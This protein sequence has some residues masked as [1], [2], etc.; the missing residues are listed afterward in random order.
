MLNQLQALLIFQN[1]NQHLKFQSRNLHRQKRV[2]NVQAGETTRVELV[3]I[4]TKTGQMAVMVSQ[5]LETSQTADNSLPKD[6]NGIT[7]QRSPKA[8][9]H[10]IAK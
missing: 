10:L 8:Q 5:W 9:I 3:Q 2:K 4:R 6:L 1:L 7:I